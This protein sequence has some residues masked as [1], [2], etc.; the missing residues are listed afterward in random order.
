MELEVGGIY[1][2]VRKP[3]HMVKLFERKSDAGRHYY[4]HSMNAKV[5]V[6]HKN[7]NTKPNKGQRYVAYFFKQV[8]V[9]HFIECLY[10]VWLEKVHFIKKERDI[11]QW[12]H[13]A[14]K[15]FLIAR[16]VSTDIAMEGTLEE[17]QRQIANIARISRLKKEKKKSELGKIL[18]FATTTT[19]KFYVT[20]DSS[21]TTGEISA[22]PRYEKE[23]TAGYWHDSIE[24][25]PEPSDYDD[26]DDDIC[27]EELEEIL[28]PIH[29]EP[30]PAPTGLSPGYM[31]KAKKRKKKRKKK[32]Q[33]P[34][35][36][37][38]YTGGY[39]KENVEPQATTP[40]YRS[41]TADKKE[42]E[43]LAYGKG[44]DPKVR[45]TAIAA[46][47]EM[48]KEDVEIREAIEKT[49]AKMEKKR[50]SFSAW[51]KEQNKEETE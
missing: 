3:I 50:S 34:I 36:Q 38:M 22:A 6:I 35:T 44:V 15:H 42:L 20:V 1:K 13:L 25:M 23:Y 49:K 10:S 41:R 37:H 51:Y 11:S 29:S 33:L 30:L 47:E 21:T 24:S 40:S 2:I 8:E 27:E 17:A 7:E 26:C 4:K 28:P 32:N 39:G 31:K 46:L 12:P 16:G 9:D 18:D 5:L 43:G 19:E 48:E 45:V 14:R